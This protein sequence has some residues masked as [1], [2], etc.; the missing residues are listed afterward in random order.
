LT[1]QGLTRAK[2]DIKTLTMGARIL[3]IQIVFHFKHVP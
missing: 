3:K 2:E 1:R